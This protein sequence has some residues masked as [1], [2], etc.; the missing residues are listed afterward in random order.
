VIVVTYYLDNFGFTSSPAV[1]LN[2]D[3]LFEETPDYTFNLTKVTRALNYYENYAD[4]T[5]GTYGSPLQ[6]TFTNSTTFNISV[7][8]DLRQL[9]ARS[10][11]TVNIFIERVVSN[12]TQES[13]GSDLNYTVSL[14]AKEGSDAYNS[15]LPYDSSGYRVGESDNRRKRHHDDGDDE[16]LNEEGKILVGVFVTIGGL[17]I[18]AVA[19][20]LYCKYCRRPKAD[21]PNFR[22]TEI[23]KL[24]QFAPISANQQETP[25][26][27]EYRRPDQG[28]QF[29]PITSSHVHLDLGGI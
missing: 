14:L 23:A 11:S 20:C 17:L 26:A 22:E 4:A 13:R 7:S 21:E 8:A 10:S 12:D 19:V 2:I 29:A 1:S 3:L 25:V 5:K 24:P 28:P 27:Q 15:Y 6:L 16:P 18:I 9:P